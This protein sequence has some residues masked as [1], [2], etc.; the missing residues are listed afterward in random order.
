MICWVVSDPTYAGIKQENF[1]KLAYDTLEN[2]LSEAKVRLRA[3]SESHLL[4]KV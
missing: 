2:G 3:S 1:V 4:I